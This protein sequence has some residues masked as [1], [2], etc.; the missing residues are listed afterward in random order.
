MIREGRIPST[1]IEILEKLCNKSDDTYTHHPNLEIKKS[2]KGYGIYVTDGPIK[3]GERLFHFKETHLIQPS[4]KIKDFIDSGKF[5]SVIGLI[6]T[7][8]HELFVKQHKSPFFAYLNSQIPPTIAHLW[9]EKEKQQLK[10]TSLLVDEKNVGLL[11]LDKIYEKDVLRLLHELGTDLFPT[12]IITKENFFT[13]F[14]W[15]YS[16]ASQDINTVRNYDNYHH[17]D[18]NNNNG[19]GSSSN[20]SSSI[21]SSAII[22]TDNTKPSI[23]YCAFI[24]IF[25]LINHTANVD[26]KN[27]SLV[28]LKLKENNAFEVYS[29][30]NLK[31]GDELYVS[32]GNYG[33][34][35][36]IRQYG[37]Y[38]S[39]IYSKVIITK[40]EVVQSIKESYCDT[41]EATDRKEMYDMLDEK[42]A[43]AKLNS[44]FQFFVL[45]KSEL[46]VN[47]DD[48]NGAWEP[49]KD[50][51]TF[52]QVLIMEDD[53]WEE[54]EKAGCI[55][56]G[57]EY[58]DFEIAQIIFSALIKLLEICSHRYN[59]FT[60]ELSASIRNDD[61]TAMAKCL[62]QEEKN[63]FSLAKEKVSLMI[64][65]FALKFAE[66]SEDEEDVDDIVYDESNDD[67]IAT[68]EFE[69]KRRRAIN[70]E[71]GK[72]DDTR[73]DKQDTTTIS[74][75]SS[76]NKKQKK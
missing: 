13:A 33:S 1:D 76:S 9:N 30:K 58:I 29:E 66:E 64:K 59:S 42:L 57:T 53:E 34:S 73:G 21:S 74:K 72:S 26:K 37:F 2:N 15:V 23:G 35:I 3:C 43:E 36:L 12:Q 38:E 27:A 55:E 54:W 16:R 70:N 40:Q 67:A 22:H 31:P 24:P 14:Q 50:L 11:D 17:Q 71:E 60:P 6:F 7:A 45:E 48:N 32:Y 63:I 28:N 47:N 41:F 10:G 5:S 61:I 20:S 18:N 56:L 69:K 75:M 62:I 68:N 49:P 25:D 65:N 46:V 19:G 39:S 8:M 44:L 51:L 52:L 4:G